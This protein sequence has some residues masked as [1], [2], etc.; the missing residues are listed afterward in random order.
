MKVIIFLTLFICTEGET[1]VTTSLFLTSK[2]VSECGLTEKKLRPTKNFNESLPIDL[3]FSLLKFYGID[4]LKQ[5]ISVLGQLEAVWQNP[6][7]SWD[8]S[9]YPNRY[10]QLPNNVVYHP[11]IQHMN[12]INDVFAIGR[13]DGNVEMTSTGEVTWLP[14]GMLTSSCSLDL[15]KFPFDTQT[16][17]IQVEMLEETKLEYFESC[18][19]SIG[20]PK[21]FLSKGQV[22]EMI[23]LS[24]NL[25]K[26]TYRHHKTVKS[27]K[28][29]SRCNFLI[30]MKRKHIYYMINMIL[31]SI[32]L[33]S[34]QVFCLALPP[35]SSQRAAFG[36]SV[37][38]SF[39][40]LQSTVRKHVPTSAE[41][42]MIDIYMSCQLVL[43]SLCTLYSLLTCQIMEAMK[44]RSR[45]RTNNTSLFGMKFIRVVDSIA[46]TLSLLSIFVLNVGSYFTIAT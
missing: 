7:V 34:L 35:S 27:T 16:C 20:D 41:T 6:C 31:P 14:T 37:L 44:K 17:T 45:S 18:S 4:D 42:T 40:I 23:S 22:W 24:A 1:P 38:L 28:W 15:F 21:G 10:I 39:A 25:T 36:I 11:V 19:L 5:Q 3:S 8:R 12:N 43:G 13:L 33:V 29:Y 26:I 9:K 32:C 46:F 30:T 2:L